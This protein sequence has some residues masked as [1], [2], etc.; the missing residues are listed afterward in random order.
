MVWDVPGVGAVG[1][2]GLRWAATR[3]TAC[4]SKGWTLVSL[5]GMQP[6][7]KGT[8]PAPAAMPTVG[9][10]PLQLG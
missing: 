7:V 5:E 9:P 10:L 6:P 4:P 1:Q 3:I 2:Q 8:E